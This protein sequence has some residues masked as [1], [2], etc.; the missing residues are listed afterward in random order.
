MKSITL[1]NLDPD[2]AE[3]LARKARA[4]GRSLNRTSQEL[5]RAAL[6]LGGPDKPDRTESSRDLFGTWSQQ[7]RREFSRRIAPL[8]RV[9]PADSEGR[10]RGRPLQA[11]RKTAPGASEG[12]FE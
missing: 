11:R 3:A 5:L 12:P 1:H 10:R 8:E 6:G 2:L 7:E 4:E 9:D